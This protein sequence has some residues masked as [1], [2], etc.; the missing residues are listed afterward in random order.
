MTHPRLIEYP[1]REA[2][3]DG[4]AAYLAARLA[5]LVAT[6]GRA[7]IALSGGSTP[8]PMLT[9]LGEADLHWE[10]VVVTLTDERQVPPSSPR[11]NQHLL[12]ETLF[13]GAAAAAVFVPLYAPAPEPADGLEA[14]AASLNNLALPL[15]I[16]VLGMGTDM[17]TAS[18]FPGAVGLDAALAADAPPAVL[19]TAPGAEEPRITLSAPVLQGAGERHLMIAGAD[20][21]AALERAL[22]LGDVR[23]AP[24]LAVLEDCTVHYAD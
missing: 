11:S 15:D 2:L 10:D 9:R 21:R 12:A 20:K 14:I 17:H 3:T 13:R 5:D 16:A 8:G 1:S 18:L 24:V 22:S 7:A 19:I 23:Q 4:L 6:T